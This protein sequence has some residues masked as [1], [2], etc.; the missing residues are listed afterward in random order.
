MVLK[1]HSLSFRVICI[2]LSIGNNVLHIAA[3][4]FFLCSVNIIINIAVVIITIMVIDILITKPSLPHV[5]SHHDHDRVQV[6]CH[7]HPP[8]DHA[9]VVCG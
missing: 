2:P 7:H 6:A 8:G 1:L 9:Q 3:C 5:M 4:G